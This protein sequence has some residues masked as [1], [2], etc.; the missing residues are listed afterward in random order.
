[1]EGIQLSWFLL[2]YLISAVLTALLT[3]YGIR[4][5]RAGRMD[6]TILAFIGTVAFSTVWSA[7]RVGEFLFVSELVTRFWLTVLYI[8]LGGGVM[9]VLFF[10]LAFTGRTHLLTQRNVGLLLVIPALTVPIAATNHIHELFWV[11]EYVQQ[12]GLWVFK[13]EF[14]PLFFAYL[15]YIQVSFAVAVYLLVRM[16]LTS[17]QVYRRQ[18]LAFMIGSAVPVTAGLLFAFDAVPGDVPR[19]FDPTPLGHAFA[20][21]CFGY[22][23]FQVNL[24][25]LVP[26]ARDTVIDNMRDG[27]VVIDTED[28]IVD[29]NE[30]AQE[31]WETETDPVGNEIH[32]VMPE[33]TP[34]LEAHSHGERLEDEITVDI[35]GGTRF[36]SVSIS[37]LTD[38]GKTIG[39]LLFLRDITDR[40]AVQKRYQRLIENSSDIILV[41]EEDGTITYVSPSIQTVMSTDPETVIGENAFEWVLAEDREKLKRGVD[42]IASTGGSTMRTEYRTLDGNGDVRV[43]EGAARNMLEDPFVEGI[44]VNARDITER[45]EREREL[46]ETNEELEQANDRLEEFASVISHDLR[47]PL[48][49]AKGRL[50]LAQ[51]LGDDEHFETVADSLDRMEAIIEDVLTLA[52]E[53]ESIGETES[54]DMAS[55]AEEAWD[56]VST[57]DAKLV[58]AEAGSLQADRARLLQLLENLFRN[59]HEHVG[60]RVTVTVG[61]DSDTFYVEDDG[62]GIPPDKREQVLESGYTTNDDGTGFGLSIVTQIAQAHGWG[63]SVTDGTDGGARFEFSGIDRD[64]T[65]ETE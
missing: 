52:R 58:V 56:H 57:D 55:V 27:Y 53:G 29:R 47:N 6:S 10:A 18:T 8:G 25:D 30:A 46:A 51:E 13:R 17:A 5:A 45:K 34:L 20:S 15:V 19:F 49:V 63:V 61:V 41:L 48:N 37:S 3:A 28:R 40:R 24:L 16:A 64:V 42:E 35:E 4:K 21:I 54:V 59:A 11:G 60:D 1:M 23:I 14:R 32:T 44:V 33:L 2:P 22:G 9:S 50:D 31:L 12:E 39:R 62:P 43:F 7:S 38:Q 65:A 36:L 26:V